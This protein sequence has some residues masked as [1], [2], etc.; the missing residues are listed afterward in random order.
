VIG[1]TVQGCKSYDTLNITNILQNPIVTLNDDPEL[2][3]GSIRTLQ[4]GNFFSYLWQDGSTI[5][6]FLV[7]DTGTYYVTVTDN[8][9]CKGS[10][11]VRILR[12]LPPPANFLPADTVICSYGNMQIMPIN[13]YSKYTWSNNASSSSISITSPGIYWLQVT[14]A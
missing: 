1:T 6:S 8:N 4:A 10:D 2:C 9:Q 13:T 7:S 3:T 14:D 11:T 5:S 12:F